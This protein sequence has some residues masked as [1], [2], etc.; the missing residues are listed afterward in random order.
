MEAVAA[1]EQAAALQPSEGTHLIL[2]E[3]NEIPKLKP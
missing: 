3:V 2:A 1:L